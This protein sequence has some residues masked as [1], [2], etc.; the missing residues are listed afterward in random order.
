MCIRQ[1]C[2]YLINRKSFSIENE[3]QA[4]AAT[5]ATQTVF[6]LTGKPGA[7]VRDI[8]MEPH[9]LGGADTR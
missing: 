5:G 9:D 3:K 1:L 8:L 7:W 4:K 2:L 6:R